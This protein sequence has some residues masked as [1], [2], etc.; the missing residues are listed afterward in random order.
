MFKIYLRERPDKK[1]P[2]GASLQNTDLPYPVKVRNIK[3][4][5]HTL[6]LFHQNSST[7]NTIS[8]ISPFSIP[9]SQT[10]AKTR[11]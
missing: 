3:G 9:H 6:R 5:K 2:K 1:D 10:L 4:I 11:I 8:V 7:Q